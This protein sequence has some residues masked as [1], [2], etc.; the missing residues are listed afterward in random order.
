[1]KVLAKQKAAESL[2]EEVATKKKELSKN[3]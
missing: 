1:M 3:N 2:A